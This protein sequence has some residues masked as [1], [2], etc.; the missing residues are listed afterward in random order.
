MRDL[1]LTL[2]V[3]GILPFALMHTW[4]AV[5]LWT[6]LS[7]MN[8][9][10]LAYGFAYDAPFAAVAAAAALISLFVTKDKVGMT[11]TS[12]VITLMAFVGWMC[13]TTALAIHPDLSWPDLVRTLKIQ[14][15]T[16]VSIAALRERK[17]IH[18]FVAV[19]ALSIGFYGLKGGLFTVATGGS[20]RVWGPPG[21]F[22]EGNNE[23]GLAIVLIIPLLNYMRMYTANAL[24]KLGVGVAM[25]L[26]AAAV[27]GTQSRGA[28][29]AISV[30]GLVMWFRSPKKL[31]SAI[32]IG[33]VALVAL[34]FMPA[35]WEE[36]MT[37]IKTYD[38]DASAMGRINA[39]WMAFNLA[40]DKFSG[41]GFHIYT[42]EI[43]A[44]YAPDPLD[45][46]AAHSIYFMALGEHGYLGLFLFVLLGVLAFFQASKIRKMTKGI[47][48]ER[49]L[50]DLAGMCQVS[51]IGFAVGGAFLSLT[52]FDLPYN[53]VVI[54][55]CG[56][57]WAQERRSGVP[58][59]PPPA[60]RKPAAAPALK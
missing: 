52:Y 44:R 26:C 53:I 35:S 57:R 50:F 48:D 45:L 11:F 51:L 58:A 59:R 20:S 31:P 60:V 38:Q 46:H 32:I 10:T 54:L 40:N 47:E 37:S 15:M 55:V 23:I 17:H 7:V 34:A 39:W 13:V 42:F 14:L 1:V 28:F 16:L 33:A 24:A 8:P 12:P 21:G 43:F 19:N 3:A 49:W 9:H 30:M 41:G 18:W 5:I 2:I 22:I 27:L 6:W 29:L 36:R 56:L 25:V 4:I